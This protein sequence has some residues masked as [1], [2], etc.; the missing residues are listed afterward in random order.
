MSPRSLSNLRR[1]APTGLRSLLLVLALL[2]LV[3]PLGGCGSLNW[4][5]F[6]KDE[7]GPDQPAEKL[8]NEGVFLLNAKQDYKDAAKKF[9]EV[10][11][12]HPYS[13]W[14][15]KALLMVAYARYEA[16]DYEDAI[17]AARRD[18]APGAGRGLCAH[19]P[20]RRCTSRSRHQYDQ[21]R[22]RR[23][24]RRSTRSAVPDTEYATAARRK[25]E[26]ARDQA[27]GKRCWWPL[28]PGSEKLTALIARFKI[29]VTQYQTTRH[30]ERR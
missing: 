3:A 29:V 1:S 24:C 12:Q 4:F 19:S 14:A 16:K 17:N 11:R 9:E 6:G 21:S 22:P 7:L 27:A 26:M 8:Y 5:G 13:E 2:V 28:L 30:V 20:A 15:R 23:H 18:A 10:E 25:T